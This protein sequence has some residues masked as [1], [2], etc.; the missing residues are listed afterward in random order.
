V[1][2][3]ERNYGLV[4]QADLL[5]CA[6]L[7]S[8]E[9]AD[10]VCTVEWVD[11]QAGQPQHANFEAA[12]DFEAL[13][14]PILSLQRSVVANSLSWDR[15]FVLTGPNTGG[16]TVLLKSV[17]LAVAMAWS[18]LPI[19]AK[20]AQIPRDLTGLFADI[21]DEQSLEQNLSTFSGHLLVLKE[22]LTH[23]H[24]GDLVLIDEIA[25]GTSPEEG[26]P[27]AQAV[28]EKLLESQVRVF[29][30]T[31][32]GSQKQFAMIDERCRIASM[33]F[34]SLHGRP[35]FEVMLDIPGES[36]A[37]EIAEQSGLP[38]GVVARARELRG[39]LS[40]DLRA[41]IERLEEARRRLITKEEDLARSEAKA[42]EREGK[43]QEKVL[44]YE[45]LQRQGLGEEARSVLKNLNSLRDEL[46]QAVKRAS[47]EVLSPASASNLFVKIGEAS[48][49]ARSMIEG[50]ADLGTRPIADDEL[51]A[52][53]I[54]EVEGFGLGRVVET[55]RDLSRGA[56][57][58]VQVQVGEIQM[59]VTR[60]KLKKP[61]PERMQK[62]KTAQAALRA[63][64]ERRDRGG[65]S[66]GRASAVAG[67]L[68]CDVRGR[69]V[70]EAMRKVEIALN[71]LSRD[72]D[73]IVTIIH[74]HGSDR[75]KDN[76]RDYIRRQRD[77]LE[78]RPG[79]WP[80]EGGDG[81]TVVERAK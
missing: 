10:P 13:R 70:P 25:T 17:G 80:G 19:P 59:S 29:V 72:E 56:K 74:G 31:H 22:A 46:S 9:W 36:S 54:V 6:A 3:F 81:V 16:K 12:L 39:E 11:S 20:A 60:S 78:Y 21:G 79:T 64:R 52:D 2:S 42:R 48:D 27:L 67:T 53:A 38:E 40:P 15:A 24:A 14:H 77:D 49:E 5:S 75:L 37:F 66:Q 23:A 4:A 18:G 69:T 63:A 8:G 76:I 62:F 71:E 61:S 65:T 73:A 26:Q 35:T 41:A 30:T 58:S 45:R 32:Y 47:S 51:K 43:A 44:E 57:T 28:I 1:E 50:E 7:L 68:V 33:A 55:P 34:D